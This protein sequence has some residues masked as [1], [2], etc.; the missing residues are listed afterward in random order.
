MPKPQIGDEVDNLSFEDFDAEPE[1]PAEE[2]QSTDESTEEQQKETSKDAE[3]TEGQ[4][5]QKEPEKTEEDLIVKTIGKDAFLRVK[6]KDYPLADFTPEEIRTFLQKGLRADQLMRESA[7]ARKAMDQERL[8]LQ[9][10]QAQV[11]QYIQQY[12]VQPSGARPGQPAPPVPPEL[13]VSE[14]DAPEVAALKKTVV[15]LKTQFDQIASGYRQQETSRGEQ[16]LVNEINSH[17]ETYPLASLEE[18]IAVKLMYPQAPVE[19][20]M[21]KSNEFYASEKYVEKV[22]QHKPELARAL[23]DKAVAKYLA[24]KGQVQNVP[25]RKSGG[26]PGHVVSKDE[27]ITEKYDFEA[28]QARVKKMLANL[29]NA[30]VTE[31]ES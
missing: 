2:S 19:Q 27:E 8:T 31:E 30:K 28:A 4:E 10:Q 17:R 24:K 5:K 21:Q 3:P 7:D 1:T 20:L 18:V 6:G 11:Q 15:D 22:L 16:A 14:Y 9:A 25:G 29:G 13:Q 26:G 23:E 12:M